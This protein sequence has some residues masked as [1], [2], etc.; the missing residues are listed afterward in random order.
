VRRTSLETVNNS[1]NPD[2]RE[3]YIKKP[4]I[5][6]VSI[7][8]SV[9]VILLMFLATRVQRIETYSGLIIT[10]VLLILPLPLIFL[11][12]YKYD[13]KKVL[14]LNKISFL[15]LL[16][17]FGIM[18]FAVLPVNY[19]NSYYLL[20]IKVIF[21]YVAAS[22][23][24][25]PT[26]A[27]GLL[28]NIL[29]IGVSAGVCEEVLFRGTIMRGFERF[30]A[31]KAILITGF[32]FGLW[33]MYF[34]SLFGTFVLGA[35]IGYI[36]YR[37]NSIYGGMFAHFCNNS[38]SVIIG[39]ISYK[40]NKESNNIDINKTFD[41][42]LNG[43]KVNLIAYF[44]STMF[45]T[46]ACIAVIVGLM[47]AFNAATSGKVQKISKE[48]NRSKLNNLLWLLPGLVFIG[49][50]YYALGL[51]FLKIKIPLVREIVKFIGIG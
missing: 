36:V 4:T 28:I 12:I 44:A 16:I 40:F 23:V 31:K 3:N 41:T 35:L 39:F 24:P 15:N 50:T 10:E 1:I 13:I 32:L 38:I 17:I 46:L 7:L 45:I 47:I 37:T 48:N 21:G 2:L 19:L 33:H 26:N 25:P 20:L 14:R 18:I 8:Y 11:F 5:K 30:G 49:F 29:I 22:N 34:T 9:S 51:A 27:V 42:L 6:Q 43:P